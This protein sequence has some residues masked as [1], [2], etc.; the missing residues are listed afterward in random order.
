MN[1]LRWLCCFLCWCSLWQV[2]LLAEQPNIVFIYCDDARWDTLGVVQRE[3]G[4]AARFPWIQTPHLD[5]LAGQSIRFRQSF[6]VH[7]LCSP[8]RAAV[9]TSTY[10]HHNGIIGNRTPLNPELPNV[11]KQLRAAGYRTGYFGKWHMDS[12]E[13][14]PGFDRVAS[15]VGQGRYQ[16][17]PLLVDGQR[18]ETEGWVDD[19]TTGYAIEFLE[20]QTEDRPFLLWLGFKSPHGPRGGENL[21][22]RARGLY[23]GQ[24]SGDVPN[25]HTPAIYLTSDERQKR[26]RRLGADTVSPGHLDFARHISAL[27]T[28]VGR[29]IAALDRSPHADRTVVIFTSDNGYYL[30]EHQ[31]GD[32]R[33]AYDEALRVPLIIRMPG[34]DAPRGVTNDAM[35]LNLDYAPTMLQLAG[36]ERL[37]EGQGKSLV[38]ILQGRTPQDWRTEFFYEYFHEAPFRAPTTLALRTT[39]HKLIV[40]PG[41]E[42]W[43]ELFDLQNDPYETSNLVSDASLRKEMVAAFE[44]AAKQSGI[45]L[46]QPLPTPPD[47]P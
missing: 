12:Q 42:S 1:R 38:P 8:G 43:T 15:F 30:G 25:L 41:N 13:E 36:A 28:C 34:D 24:K 7:S 31:L 47:K 35:V 6:V 2:R 27:D 32:K 11:A 16:D 37:P 18:T 33:S 22:P 40:Y 14:R 17:C 20:E 39:R 4:D 45:D 44:A 46:S 5:A 19:V 9:L 3:Q 23:A 29:L 21:P 26:A 10:G